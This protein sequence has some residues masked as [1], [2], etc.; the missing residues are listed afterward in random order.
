MKE[1]AH[2]TEAFKWDK[3]LKQK[4]LK[5]TLFVHLMNKIK[6][7]EQDVNRIKLYYIMYYKGNIVFVESE[8]KIA[9]FYG[10][11]EQKFVK[12]RTNFQHYEK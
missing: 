1:Y 2:G 6:K 7:E 3:G 4:L 12:Q 8:K 5:S 9:K 10:I 11:V